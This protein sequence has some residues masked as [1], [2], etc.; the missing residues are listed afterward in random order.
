MDD[1]EAPTIEVVSAYR[2]P[3]MEAEL[4]GENQ[5]KTN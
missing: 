2:V 3:W 1:I 4:T 5:P